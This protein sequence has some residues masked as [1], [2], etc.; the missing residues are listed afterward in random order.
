MSQHQVNCSIDVDDANAAWEYIREF[1]S[2]WHPDI[3]SVTQTVNASGAVVREFSGSDGNNYRE[4]RTYFS[5]TDQLLRY[6]MTD[7]IASVEHYCGEAFVLNTTVKW[8]CSFSAE[9]GVGVPV[10]EGSKAIFDNGLE[11][12]Q[13]NIMR[14]NKKLPNNSRLGKKKA[15]TIKS[16]AALQRETI[17]GGTELSARCTVPAKQ[18]CWTLVL[19]LHGIGGNADNWKAQLK[20]LGSSYVAAALDLRG[21][22][23]SKLGET[24][25]RVDD[26][27]EDIIRVMKHFGARKLVLVGLSMGSWIAT[28]FAMRHPQLLSGLVLAGGCT[29]MSEAHADERN[30]FLAARA[31]PL[32]AGK[33]P[34]D[35]AEN[36]V[37]VISGPNAAQT[38]RDN[39]YQ[40]MASITS[41]TYL[42][43]LNCFTQPLEVFDFTRINCPV[44]LVT[45]EYDK[46]APPD[47]IRQISLRIF[48]EITN[49]GAL[50]DICFEVIDEAGHL[51]NIENSTQFNH[52]LKMFLA[53][54]PGASATKAPSRESL[55]E[56]KNRNI[57]DAALQEFSAEGYDGASMNSI[58]ESARVSKPTLYQ[59]FDDKDG[60]FAAVLQDGCEHITTPLSTPDGILVDRLWNFSWVYADFVLRT[61]MLSLAR[62]VLGE[63]SRRPQIT[64]AYHTAGP[65]KAFQGLVKFIT[66][67]EEAGELEVDDVEYAAQDL[68]SLILSGPRDYHLHF[69]D[70]RPDRQ[71]LL[72]SISHGLRI[73]IKVYSTD[74][75]N[76]LKALD[77]KVA[78]FSLLS[79][80]SGE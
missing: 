7:G 37:S 38:Q 80:S 3:V 1:G 44:L 36:V 34:K 56:L 26:H 79:Q 53:R 49:A 16:N 48:N 50:P 5:D 35:F 68:W 39:L 51:C 72:R 55:R 12:L 75:Q 10:A 20:S 30:R 15:K 32:A 78:G 41:A 22:G 43:A 21:Y 64:K 46:L 70:R 67:C 14:P 24:Q 59:Y 17:A 27:C 74:V 63:A 8:S 28:S 66:A 71:Q 2:D 6:A 42:D 13:H 61:D 65:G 47:E 9:S 45:G 76:D 29:G 57:L 40:S 19:F 31:E 58:A 25:T 11:W 77:E 33:T 60:L 54:L 52:L 62:L 23:K 73:F 69:V 18:P 4:Q